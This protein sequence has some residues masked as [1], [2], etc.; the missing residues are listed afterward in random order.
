MTLC[1]SLI[2]LFFFKAFKCLFSCRYCNLKATYKLLPSNNN[3]ILVIVGLYPEGSPSRNSRWPRETQGQGGGLEIVFNQQL[4]R[5]GYYLIS[6]VIAPSAK[7]ILLIPLHLLLY[8]TTPLPSICSIR[9]GTTKQ[10]QLNVLF[11]DLTVVERCC[12]G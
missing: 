12:F 1:T 10:C 4:T 6:C 2:T 11:K 7:I 5:L 8:Y 3:F 9:C